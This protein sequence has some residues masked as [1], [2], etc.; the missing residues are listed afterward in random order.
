MVVDSGLS[1]THAA[2]PDG[3]MCAVCCLDLDSGNYVEYRSVA[4]GKWYPSPYCNT[5]I[6]AF[7]ERKWDEWVHGV[8]QAD[9][10]VW[11]TLFIVN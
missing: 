8:E 6:E 1:S 5:C 4:G 7:L 10:Q 11:F 3:E 2:I 9:C